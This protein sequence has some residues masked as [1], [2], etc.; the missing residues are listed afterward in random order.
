MRGNALALNNQGLNGITQ[1]INDI[2]KGAVTLPVL[3]MYVCTNWTLCVRLRV[4]H[5]A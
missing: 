3:C 1:R 5:V 2:A 4:R